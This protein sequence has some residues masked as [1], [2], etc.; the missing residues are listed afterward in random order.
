MVSFYYRVRNFSALVLELPPK[1]SGAEIRG[2]VSYLWEVFMHD[3]T[4]MWSDPGLG[5]KAYDEPPSILCGIYR[6]AK[7]ERR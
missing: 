4:Q 3:Y 6:V 7:Q 2:R 1:E 5:P